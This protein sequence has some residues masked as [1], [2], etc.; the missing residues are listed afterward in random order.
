[1]STAVAVTEVVASQLASP[2][3]AKAAAPAAP[4]APAVPAA[5]ATEKADAAVA[6]PTTPA[7]ALA[8]PT[9]RVDDDGQAPPQLRGIPREVAVRS[10]L[11]ALLEE[12]AILKQRWDDASQRST[13]P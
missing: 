8:L 2:A 1:M 5:P 6:A 3:V 10:G 4:A 7:V 13:S 9:A 11:I 12:K